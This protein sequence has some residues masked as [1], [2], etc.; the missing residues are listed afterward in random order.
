[1]RDGAVA[2]FVCMK[3]EFGLGFMG[4]GMAKGRICPCVRGLGAGKS[5]GLLY[6]K[7]VEV[8]GKQDEY[9]LHAASVRQTGSAPIRGRCLWISTIL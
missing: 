1:M 2:S 8:F 7:W 4:E 9:R 5:F 3:I 6:I